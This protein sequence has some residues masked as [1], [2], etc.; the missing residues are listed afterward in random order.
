MLSFQ[1]Y[2]L[3]RDIEGDRSKVDLPD[4]IETGDGE[5]EAWTPSTPGEYPTQA[6]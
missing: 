2:L 3:G 4:H 5:E 1:T 6:E